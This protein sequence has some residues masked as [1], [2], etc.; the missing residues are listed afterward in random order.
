MID[1]G[2]STRIPLARMPNWEVSDPE[3][4]KSEWW[5]WDYEGSRKYFNVT[6]VNDKGRELALGIDTKNLTGPEELY[7]GAVAWTE[8]GWVDG[9]PY[10]SYVQAFD[11]EK[12][13][14]GFEGYWEMP[15]RL[16]QKSQILPLKIN[17]IT[18][19]TKRRI[20]VRQKEKEDEYNLILPDGK[21]PNEGDGSRKRV[22]LNI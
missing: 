21:N 4:V 12:K 9:T 20:L 6:I 15:S 14:I 22:T 1:A 8:F 19:M 17:H 11:A 18:W 3:D 7:M 5:E 2:E 10:P 13:G 16:S